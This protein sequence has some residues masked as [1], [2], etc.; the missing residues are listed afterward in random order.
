MAVLQLPFFLARKDITVK[1]LDSHQENGQTWRVLDVT[2]PE[3][4]VLA[5]HS[6]TQQYYFD[7]NFILQRHDYAPDVLA[8]SGAAHYVYDDV[9][10]G[11]IKLPTLR[12]V[13]AINPANGEPL[14]HGPIPTLIH[15]V[16][17]SIQVNKDGAKGD[18][19]NKWALTEA[20]RV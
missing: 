20:P 10:V 13:L 14:Y 19:A 12:R 7:E 5:S 17:Q 15:L 2:F 9:E 8:G 6:K 3:N 18:E 4:D 11:G 1:E 16:L